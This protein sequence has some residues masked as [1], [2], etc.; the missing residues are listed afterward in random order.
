M[1]SPAPGTEIAQRR[2]A[3]PVV[4]EVLGGEHDEGLDVRDVG[5]APQRVKVIRRRG[6]VD[7]DEV[8]RGIRVGFGPVPHVPVPVRAIDSSSVP[9][10]EASDVVVHGPRARRL[11]RRGRQR[12]GV[13]LGSDCSRS[14]SGVC[15]R[16]V[17]VK[18]VD[19]DDEAI[20]SV[21]GLASDTLAW[22]STSDA[23]SDATS[24]SIN[25]PCSSK[26]VNAWSLESSTSKPEAPP[27]APTPPPPRAPPRAP[28]AGPGR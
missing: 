3:R 26:S 18:I 17:V 9:A 11:D 22:D 28:S 20:A 12:D 21:A 23:T 6:G 5:L 13:H 10:E 8:A 27:P 14:C 24:A 4:E 16:S 1:N 7:E 15:G 19:I 2:R 25:A